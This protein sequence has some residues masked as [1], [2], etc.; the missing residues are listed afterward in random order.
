MLK[1]SV[2]EGISSN[3]FKFNIC[4]VV[5][6]KSTNVWSTI[7][8]MCLGTQQ[9]RKYQE[10]SSLKTAPTKNHGGVR[11]TRAVG[12]PKR[13]FLGI[14][15]G[16]GIRCTVAHCL[17]KKHSPQGRSRKPSICCLVLGMV[18]LLGISKKHFAG[19]FQ[20]HM[21]SFLGGIEAW[22]LA[23]IP[24]DGWSWTK[25]NRLFWGKLYMDLGG[26][27][28]KMMVKSVRE[29]S[30]KCARDIQVEELE[31]SLP[32]LMLSLNTGPRFS[33]ENEHGTTNRLFFERSLRA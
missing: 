32:G 24:F 26:G 6:L 14:I 8:A 28:S 25:K 18:S 19:C 9:P 4:F 5:N 21:G 29:V 31:A 33:L 27:H 30:P 15:T 7:W 22:D 11:F 2:F 3:S 16:L 17:L 23:V 12:I 20:V 13:Y 1:E 10:Q